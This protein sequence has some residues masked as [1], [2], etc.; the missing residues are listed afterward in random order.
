MNTV[1]SWVIIIVR[2]TAYRV[3]ERVREDVCSR[4]AARTVHEQPQYF[5]SVMIYTN[6]RLY[7]RRQH[8]VQL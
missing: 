4:A 6:S 3:T 1:F 5:T 7:T 2:T 8:I